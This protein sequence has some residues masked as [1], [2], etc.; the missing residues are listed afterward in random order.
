LFWEFY[1][2]VTSDSSVY[3]R[4]AAG[5]HPPH[6]T[7]DYRSSRARHPKE[8]LVIIPQTLSELTGPAYPYGHL[9]ALDSD[10][11]RQHAGD[12]IGQRITLQGRV[13]DEDGRPIPQTLVEIWQANAAGRYTHARDN[14]RAPLDP[15][16]S[17]AGRT[18][19]DADGRWRFVTIMPGAYPWPNHHNA[20]RPRHVHFSLFGPNFL[21]RLITQMYFPGDPLHALDPVLNSVPDPRGRERLVCNFDIN[22]TE[23]DWALGFSWDIVLRGRNATPMERL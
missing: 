22:L 4:P 2:S 21:T 7:G 1:M 13:L 10:L 17:G 14:N 23:P 18:L 11:T 15:N 12:P 5:V 8:P 3:P 9:S 6:T 20:W 16:F 19:T